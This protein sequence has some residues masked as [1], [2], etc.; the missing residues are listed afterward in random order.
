VAVLLKIK[1]ISGINS[2]L[3]ITC[4]SY[5]KP[6]LLPHLQLLFMTYGPGIGIWEDSPVCLS[7]VT[8]GDYFSG[9][10]KIWGKKNRI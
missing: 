10:R 4:L 9:L 8:K 2:K 6:K 5:K 1:G 7:I 3:F